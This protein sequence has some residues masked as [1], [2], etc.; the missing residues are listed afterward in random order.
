MA[1]LFDLFCFI[2]LPQQLNLLR[3]RCPLLA[4]ADV[5]TCV[6]RKDENE[7]MALW[8]Q[9]SVFHTIC[10]IIMM[11]NANY[12]FFKKGPVSSTTIIFHFLI[13]ITALFLETTLK[14]PWFYFSGHEKTSYS[15]FDSKDFFLFIL[16][17]ANKLQTLFCYYK[18]I[19]LRIHL[20]EKKNVKHRKT[21]LIL[22]VFL[23]KYTNFTVWQVQ[24]TRKE[25]K[26]QADLHLHVWIGKQARRRGVEPPL[27]R[28]GQPD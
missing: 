9:K 21:F 27:R 28:I 14:G 19:N 7:R 4:Q 6:C 12:V 22:F 13:L 20:H 11:I 1:K 26:T 5:Q 2:P 16:I 8:R 10:S 3:S 15:P 23:E 24:I 25:P 18:E 17:K